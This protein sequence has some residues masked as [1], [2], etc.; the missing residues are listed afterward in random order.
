MSEDLG[1]S[2][3]AEL[4]GMGV[5]AI[6]DWVKDHVA[7]I[8]IDNETGD[9]LERTRHEEHHGHFTVDDDGG[10]YDYPYNVV[11]TGEK[12]VCRAE[13]QGLG[14]DIEVKIGYKKK[15]DDREIFVVYI[16]NPL[17]GVNS[18]GD[19]GL[20]DWAKNEYTLEE[21]GNFRKDI[22]GNDS[23]HC[24]AGFVLK[25]EFCWV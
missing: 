15:G 14:V 2:F 3:F 11:K 13:T 9:E 10:P 7:I 17:S 22:V 20:T 12:F 21:S 24:A 19:T 23:R 25:S 1:L 8:G 16:W 4:F 18:Y 6:S 5:D